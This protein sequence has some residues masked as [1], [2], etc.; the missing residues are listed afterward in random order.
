MGH[1]YII[2]VYI[3]YTTEAMSL[4]FELITFQVTLLSLRTALEDTVFNPTDGFGSICELL[5]V[6]LLPHSQSSSL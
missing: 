5:P 4:L 2:D 6:P 3:T 1:I